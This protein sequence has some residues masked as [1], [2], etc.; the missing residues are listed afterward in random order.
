MNV[1]AGSLPAMLIRRLLDGDAYLPSFDLSSI[2]LFVRRTRHK[3]CIH[4]DTM[5]PTTCPHFASE[6]IFR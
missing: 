2:N 3:S 4:S 6:S 1:V 5:F